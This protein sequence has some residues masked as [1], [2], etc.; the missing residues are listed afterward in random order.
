MND[1]RVFGVAV[2]FWSRIASLWSSNTPVRAVSFHFTF[3][4]TVSVFLCRRP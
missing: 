2:E 3:L 1:V 4:L